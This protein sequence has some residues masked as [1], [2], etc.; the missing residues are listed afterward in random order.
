MRVLPAVVGLALAVSVPASALRPFDMLGVVP[1]KVEGRQAQ[2]E[3]GARRNVAPAAGVVRI[4]VIV[5]DARGRALDNLSATDFELREDGEPQSIDEV[6]FV[7]VDR[8]AG[9]TQPPPIRSERD[10][11]AEAA[12]GN[13]RL[14]AIFLDDYHVGGGATTERVRETLTRFVDRDLGPRDLVTVM[15]PLDSLLAIR[16]TRDRDE[17]HQ[18]IDA[19]DGR[20]GAYEPRT[21]FE[22]NYLATT[23]GSIEAARAQLT[24]SA[25]SAL[26]IHLGSLGDARKTIVLVSEGLPR[27]ERRRGLEPLPTFES[28]VRA[29]NRS[30]VSIYVVDPRRSPAGGDDGGT[31]AGNPQ[32]TLRALANETD[33]EAIVN[34]ADLDNAMRRIVGDASAYYLVTYHSARSEDGQFHDV[35]V[36]VKRPDVRV[37]ARKG[38]WAPTRGELMRAN[39]LAHAHD[40]APVVSIA[41]ARRISPLVSPWFGL[42]R[43]AGGKTRVTFVWEPAARVPGDRTTRS[44]A[45]VVLTALGADNVTV[46]E[47]PVVPAGPIDPVD[48]VPREGR[49]ARA[50]FEVAPGRLRLRMSIEDA[51]GRVVDSDVREIAV[52]DLRAPVVVGTPEVLRARTARDVR[53]LAADPDAV[54]VASREFSR[55]EQLIIR[56]PAYAP[57]AERPRVSAKL[58]SRLGKAMRDVPVQP[59]AAPD[60]RNQIALPL[61]GLAAGE[62][63]LEITA[64]SPAGEAR[65]LV[66]FRVTS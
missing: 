6:R 22:R 3:V 40:P 43:G 21:A 28:V 32:E 51:A 29:A 59:V 47:G 45:R 62:Y 4:D 17:V 30:N 18:A 7:K 16:L 63:Q 31:I 60:G 24:M 25:L 20:K 42:A 53:A 55:A 36:Q 15:K 5:A 46:F 26:A 8:A 13:T 19:F 49:S 61:A 23:P 38:Y 34:A 9:G 37:R 12:S 64:S 50:V 65:D 10:E 14:V 56:F 11:H 41:P 44:P 48:I 52:R 66:S 58:L 57:G 33:G 1:S 54:P 27:A 39:I 35:Q 2:G